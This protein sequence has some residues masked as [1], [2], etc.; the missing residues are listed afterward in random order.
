MQLT[1]KKKIVDKYIWKCRRP[2]RKEVSIR[3]DSIFADTRVSSDVFFNFL[4]KWSGGD[5]QTNVSEDLRINKNTVSMWEMRVCGVIQDYLVREGQ[6]LGGVDLEG[7]SIVVE[8]DESLFFRRKYNRG[9]FQEAQWVFGL[10][11]RGSGKCA[12]FPIA[13]RNADLLISL[14]CEM[15]RPGSTIISDSSA[16]YRSISSHAEFTHLTVSQSIN[17]INP[18][19][20]II[21]TQIIENIL[22]HA[23][24]SLRR[25]FG[26]RGAH[27]EGYLY[28]FIFKKM[29]K[30]HLI[31]NKLVLLQKNGFY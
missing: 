31:I 17:F 16:A 12:L 26:C 29:I 27:L 4:I 18:E 9:S 24:R 1:E 11:K 28:E 8:I 22:L 21:H 23:K 5:L 20:L 6:M 30:R 19:N 7:K 3:K 14:I 15:Y 25:D 2:C 10:I 13:N